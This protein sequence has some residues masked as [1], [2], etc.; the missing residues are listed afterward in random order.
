MPIHLSSQATI[1]FTAIKICLSFFSNTIN[2]MFIYLR[3]VIGYPFHII[4]HAEPL[5]LMG[6]CSFIRKV[7]VAS[8]FCCNTSV[9][10]VIGTMNEFEWTVGFV[11]SVKNSNFV[12]NM[13]FVRFACHIF[14]MSPD[15]RLNMCVWCL[16]LWVSMLNNLIVT[17]WEWCVQSQLK[18]NCGYNN[19]F[20]FLVSP[21]LIAIYCFNQLDNRSNR[22][23]RAL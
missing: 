10:N 2:F 22:M 4:S 1:S 17:I 8:F 6:G 21:K 11:S 16:T 13:G 23:H 9:S 5:L 3:L 20:W 15:D 7:N 12:E 14:K 19:R 18:P